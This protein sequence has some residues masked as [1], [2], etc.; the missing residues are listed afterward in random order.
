MR[1]FIALDL[2]PVVKARLKEITLDF[3]AIRGLKFVEPENSHLTLLFIGEYDK[4]DEIKEKL[5]EL[6]FE[7]FAIETDNVGYFEH[8][9]KLKVFWLGLEKSNE[10]FAL[11]KKIQDLFPFVKNDFDQFNPHLTIARANPDADASRLKEKITRYTSR[12]AHM[13]VDSVCLYSSTLQSGSVKYTLLSRVDA[14]NQKEK[15]KK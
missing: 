7:P 2:P 13:N 14:K 12:A 4:P 5:K 3:Q 6:D 10:L 11:Q 1:L 9:N 8:N 15:S